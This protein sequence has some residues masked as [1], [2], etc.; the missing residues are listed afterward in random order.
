MKFFLKI[1]IIRNFDQNTVAIVQNAY[2]KKLIKKY[3]IDVVVKT[4]FSFFSDDFTK[5]ENEIDS[6]RVHIYKKKIESIC[7]SIVII[8]LDVVKAVFKLFEFL[9][10]PDSNHLAAANQCIRYLYAIRFLEIR[11]STSTFE[12]QLSMQIENEKFIVFKIFET[13]ADVSY[14]N[15]SNRK[16]DEN[17]TFRFFDDLIN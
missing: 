7:Y 10:N 6:I 13:T 9:I 2:M 4:S 3:D 14:A 15:Y 12:N 1:R 17:Y 11:Y 8:R 5:H 16:N